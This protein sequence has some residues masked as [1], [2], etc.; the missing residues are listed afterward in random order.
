MNATFVIR[1]EE[2]KLI[3]SINE[4][5]KNG[6]PTHNLLSSVQIL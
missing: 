6:N 2:S 4:T 1:L 3:C 5:K